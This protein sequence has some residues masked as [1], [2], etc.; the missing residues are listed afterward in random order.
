MKY[1]ENP[2]ISQNYSLVASLCPKMEIFSILAK[3][4]WKKKLIICRD[5]LFHIKTR[6][7]LKYFVNGCRNSKYI[8]VHQ[9]STYVN[10]FEK[11][12]SL[13]PWYRVGNVSF[14][15]TFT[16]IL[17]GWPLSR[18]SKYALKY[19]TVCH[20]RLMNDL[21]GKVF[22]VQTLPSHKYMFKITNK[23][24]RLMR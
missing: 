7:S 13:K 22:Q 4:C 17:N 23:N 6:V 11:L 21:S 5:A 24:T 16:Y 19:W 8:R 14:L 2:K 12:T 20:E 18:F 10:F 1:Q 15:E 9:F 3:N